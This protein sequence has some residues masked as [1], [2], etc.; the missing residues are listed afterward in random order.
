MLALFEGIDNPRRER[1]VLTELV[2]FD[3]CWAFDLRR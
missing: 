2:D 1:L 3:L